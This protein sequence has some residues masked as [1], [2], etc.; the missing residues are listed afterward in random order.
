MRHKHAHKSITIISILILTVI[1]VIFAQHIKYKPGKES[2]RH[3]FNEIEQY[4]WGSFL[5]NDLTTARQDLLIYT[6]WLEKNQKTIADY[7]KIHVVKRWAYSLLG[8]LELYAGNRD[9]SLEYFKIAIDN[10]ILSYDKEGK[11]NSHKEMLDLVELGSST[12]FFNGLVTTNSEHLASGQ[13]ER[14]QWE[15]TGWRV[16]LEMEIDDMKYVDNKLKEIF[17]VKGQ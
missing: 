3:K 7:K 16:G 17:K 4:T 10:L 5:T 8:L 11:I 14:R 13:V 2:I 15:H 6:S 1:A 12:R 9:S